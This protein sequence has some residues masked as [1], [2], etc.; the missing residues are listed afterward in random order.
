M[1]TFL[2]R[3]RVRSKEKK[4]YKTTLFLITLFVKKTKGL[5]ATNKKKKKLTQT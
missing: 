3:E 1:L 5:L 4:K 2:E